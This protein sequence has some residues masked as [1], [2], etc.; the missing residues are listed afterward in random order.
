MYGL[1]FKIFLSCLQCFSPSSVF[2]LLL[3]LNLVLF[4]VPS[5]V[6]PL[7]FVI[8]VIMRFGHITTITHSTCITVRSHVP[9]SSSLD[10]ALHLVNTNLCTLRCSITPHHALRN[11]Q[12]HHVVQPMLLVKLLR[13][14]SYNFLKLFLTISHHCSSIGVL[15]HHQTFLRESCRSANLSPSGG[16]PAKNTLTLKLGV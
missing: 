4:L 2:T 15:S 12:L 8:P 11:P 10:Y 5:V 1:S 6:P 9:L 3:S 14:M 13:T 7:G 16:G